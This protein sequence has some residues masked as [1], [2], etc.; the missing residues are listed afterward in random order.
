VNFGSQNKISF[1]N[2]DVR[3]IFTLEEAIFTLEEA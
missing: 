3:S 2:D 1:W